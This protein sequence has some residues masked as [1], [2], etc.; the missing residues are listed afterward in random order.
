MLEIISSPKNWILDFSHMSWVGQV[1]HGVSFSWQEGECDTHFLNYPFTVTRQGQVW[2]NHEHCLLNGRALWRHLGRHPQD[3]EHQGAAGGASARG[4][5]RM[6]CGTRPAEGAATFRNSSRHKM[7]Q[8]PAGSATSVG[9]SCACGRTRLLTP[10]AGA[11]DLVGWGAG[12][13]S[14]ALKAPR[15]PPPFYRGKNRGKRQSGGRR[16][17]AMRTVA[18]E[19]RP[20]SDSGVSHPQHAVTTRAVYCPSSA[21]FCLLTFGKANC[22][23]AEFARKS[24]RT[25]DLLA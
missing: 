15:L 23:A 21:P 22:W 12:D 7:A 5:N 2:K 8:L 4:L 11:G 18:P 14:K 20:S 3:T 6:L 24:R 1:F 9:S 10:K 19:R 16:T 13:L 17:N 25:P